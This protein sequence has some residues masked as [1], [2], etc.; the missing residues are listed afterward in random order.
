MRA[1]IHM[2]N[3]FSAHAAQAELLA[4]HRQAAPAR[5]FLVHGEPAAMGAFRDCL[6]DTRVEMPS[7]HEIVDLRD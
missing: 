2:I 3:G 1:P 4:W 6:R 5:T 7:L